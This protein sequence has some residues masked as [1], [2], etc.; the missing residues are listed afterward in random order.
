MLT[1]PPTT[2]SSDSSFEAGQV[3]HSR[4]HTFAGIHRR[5]HRP[6]GQQ[7]SIFQHNASHPLS[8]S[9]HP[10]AGGKRSLGE[11]M[12][13]VL[14]CIDSTT[15]YNPSWWNRAPVWFVDSRGCLESELFGLDSAPANARRKTCPDQRHW[16]RMWK[17]NWPSLESKQDQKSFDLKL[18]SNRDSKWHRLT[19][20]WKSSC[21]QGLEQDLRNCQ[22][23]QAVPNGPKVPPRCK[24]LCPQSHPWKGSWCLGNRPQPV[25]PSKIM[26][27]LEVCNSCR[28]S[29]SII[30]QHR[31]STPWVNTVSQHRE[32][33]PWVNTHEKVADVWATAP[34]C[35]RIFKKTSKIMHWFVERSSRLMR[36]LNNS[37]KS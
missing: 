32:S 16:H 1:R 11:L 22:Y 35:P 33:T 7:S 3:T 37:T 15:F 24:S 31:E 12:E 19:M 5:N 27:G 29:L 14:I 36:A 17:Q 26:Q 23:H 9:L 4:C 21:C 2:R 28:T 8:W 30:C 25:K 10:E 34:T 13:N 6:T 20:T 18:L